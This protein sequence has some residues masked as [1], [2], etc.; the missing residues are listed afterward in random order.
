M[1]DHDS[2]TE[3]EMV[4]QSSDQP[5]TKNYSIAPSDQKKETKVEPTTEQKKEEIRVE[6]ISGE[7]KIERQTLDTGTQTGEPVINT[8]VAIL[9]P[10]IDNMTYTQIRKIFADAYSKM[11]PGDIMYLKQV[12]MM[13][14]DKEYSQ[15][16]VFEPAKVISIDHQISNN[17]GV[18]SVLFQRINGG[19]FQ[20]Q[21]AYDLNLSCTMKDETFV[22]IIDGDKRRTH[23]LLR[24]H[25]KLADVTN[26]VCVLFTDEHTV[27]P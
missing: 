4:G 10:L 8:D 21:S 2:D 18:Y 27:Q 7:K 11:V 25:E 15:S 24:R 3:F 19:Q 22:P 9:K 5:F 26:R 1:T 6:L 16:R 13:N 12:H 23:L 14:K 20:I 17:E